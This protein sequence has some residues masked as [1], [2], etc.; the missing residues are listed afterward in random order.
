MRRL[1]FSSR[2]L[3]ILIAS[4]FSRP[5][6][7]AAYSGHLET[8]R[9]L[10]RHGANV[11]NALIS[12]ISRI[13]QMP[14]PNVSTHPEDTSRMDVLRCR[15]HYEDMSLALR[16]ALR[17]QRYDEDQPLTPRLAALLQSQ[18]FSLE[19]WSSV[20][21]HLGVASASD[22]PIVPIEE[23]VCSLSRG[24]VSEHQLLR[25]VR[26]WDDHTRSAGH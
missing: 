17:M 2:M 3:V 4:G 11:S 13:R 19:D 9:V 15:E 8:V 1:L 18:D 16:R 24:H 14:L 23:V 5:L 7:L 6:E 10:L 22:I 26:L 25:T 12:R 21:A 20:N